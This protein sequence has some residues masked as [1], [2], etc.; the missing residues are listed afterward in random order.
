MTKVL[1]IEN[2]TAKC[3]VSVPVIYGMIDGVTNKKDV[4]D[5]AWRSALE[6]RIVKEKDKEKY[7]FVIENS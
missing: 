7:S 1:I 4:I 5:E 3:V 6:D 2:D